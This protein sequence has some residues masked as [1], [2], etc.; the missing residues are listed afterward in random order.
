VTGAQRRP[1]NGQ[2]TSEQRRSSL[3]THAG[4]ERERECLAEGANEQEKVG[5]RGAGLKGVEGV[6]RWPGN[7]RT[8]ACPR[9]ECAGGRLVTGLDGWGP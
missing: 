3:G 8:W 1:Q 2:R 6:R 9:R 7:A 4:R 5:E